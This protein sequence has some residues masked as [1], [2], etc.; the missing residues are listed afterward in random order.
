MLSADD[1]KLGVESDLLC[2]PFLVPLVVIGEGF[3]GEFLH[4]GHFKDLSEQ[5]LFLPWQLE[6]YLLTLLVGLFLLESVL[7]ILRELQIPKLLVL[8]LGL[9][10]VNDLG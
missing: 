1:A 6:G 2:S 8:N 5:V 3:L 4:V 7:G 9:L 10:H